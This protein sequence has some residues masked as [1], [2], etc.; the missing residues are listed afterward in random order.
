M[1]EKITCSIGVICYNEETNINSLLD[2]LLNQNLHEVEILKIIVV[3]SACTDRTDEIVQSYCQKDERISLIM[4]PTRE[5][6]SSAINLF[7]R[8]AAGDI[9]ILESGDT[10]PY[11]NTIEKLV[12][13][14][15]NPKI[16]MVGTRPI[17]VDTDTNFMGYVVHLLWKLHHLIA[18]E[19]PKLGE[20]VAFRN[21]VKQI[22]KESAVDEASIEAII[23]Q[24]GYE[25]YYDGNAMVKNKGAETVSD[26]LKQRRRIYAGH[27]W[28]TKTQNYEV[29][30]QNPFHIFKYLLQIMEWSP[31]KVLWSLGAMIL[32]AWGR[33]LGMYDFYIK[34][35]NPYKWEISES[36]KNL[37]NGKPVC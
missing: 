3:S 25:L 26:F 21:I 10:I 32:E 11:P 30:T 29:A 37:T 35:K 19:H 18:M 12:L 1:S 20:M 27:L 28:L 6:K 34:K 24:N 15:K 4:Q 23:T 22:P 14:F 33:F 2:G 7:L 31:H 17:P 8:E 16:G 9:C 36:T 13:P 5:G